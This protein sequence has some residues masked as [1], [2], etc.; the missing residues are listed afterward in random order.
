MTRWSAATVRYEFPLGAV[1]GLLA[2]AIA[3]LVV[4]LARR[5]P[6]IAMGLV[7]GLLFAAAMEPVQRLAFGLV[8]TWGQIVRSIIWSP[9]MTDP[10]MPA[11]GATVGAIIGTI[12]AAVAVRRERTRTSSD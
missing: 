6:S 1:V 11:F 12:I 10:Y 4:V 2:G 3:G 8:L 7:I 5:R 9:G